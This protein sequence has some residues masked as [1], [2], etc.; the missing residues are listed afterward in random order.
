MMN[1]KFDRII[2][3][4]TKDRSGIYTNTARRL[5]TGSQNIEKDFWVC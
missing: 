4:S 3:L 5:D 1:P 2:R